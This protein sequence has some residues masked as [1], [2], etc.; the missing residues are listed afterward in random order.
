M[1]H[2]WLIHWLCLMVA[3]AA[4]ANN[5]PT[6]GHHDA[7]G[8]AQAKQT[9]A[10]DDSADIQP[11]KALLLF[12]AEWDET[13][14]GQWLEPTDFAEDS[15]FTEQL[16]SPNLQNKTPNAHENNPDHL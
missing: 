1:N 3:N 5:P 9:E 8:D 6:S 15:S 12:L 13:Q 4:A 10:A 16:E 7:R 14:D 11:D 2:R